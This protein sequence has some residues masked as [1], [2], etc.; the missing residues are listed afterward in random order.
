MPSGR[1]A[2]RRNWLDRVAVAVWVSL[3]LL[4]VVVF[5]AGL[6]VWFRRLHEPC[7]DTAA[8]CQQQLRLSPADEANLRASGWSVDT[9]AWFALGTRGLAKLL[10]IGLGVLIF[11]RRPA[12]RMALVASL[13]L[14]LG[15]ETSVYEALVREAPGW[16]LAARVLSYGGGLCFAL[17]FYLFPSGE[18][19]PAWTRWPAL[20]WAVVFGLESGLPGTPLAINNWPLPLVL[21]VVLAFMGTFG[22]AQIY[23]YRRVSGQ[24]ERRQTRWVVFATAMSLI[25]FSATAISA[26]GSEQRFAPGW[27]LTD[28]GF[29]QMSILVPAAIGI[30][31]LRNRLWDIDVIIRRTLVYSL[32]S[33]LLAGVY[34]GSVL[35][36]QGTF[37]AVTGN[38]ES[39]LVTVLST[40]AIAALFFP[41]RARVQAF[42]DRR[43]YRSKYDA[44]RTLAVFAQAAR[45]E[46]DLRQLTERLVGTVDEAM[47]PASVGLWLRK[48]GPA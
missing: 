42:I 29:S 24:A 46:T 27:I 16:W 40:L 12:G 18:F 23:R 15:L 41:L 7:L 11:W 48:E 22:F 20:A 14:I 31:V 1:A 6:G 19:V 10:G 45:D 35:V 38:R 9:Y 3:L 2:P 4:E 8:A 37:G 33:A 28:L 26:I 17:F 32:L 25:I 39:P 47:Q 44:A 36:L 13:F 34:L 21:G 43:F 30:A 5:A